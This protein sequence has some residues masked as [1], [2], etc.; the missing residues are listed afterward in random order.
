MPDGGKKRRPAD[1]VLY[2]YSYTEGEIMI[3]LPGSVL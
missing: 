2:I 1:V 3:S